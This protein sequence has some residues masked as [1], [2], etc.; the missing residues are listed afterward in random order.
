MNLLSHTWDHQRMHIRLH[1]VFVYYPPLCTFSRRYVLTFE[2]QDRTHQTTGEIEV[3]N[4]PY[5]VL[6]VDGRLRDQPG[7]C[8]HSGRQYRPQNMLGQALQ[9]RS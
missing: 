2:A 9:P 7:R 1:E 5:L 4:G 6:E 3:Q 8:G